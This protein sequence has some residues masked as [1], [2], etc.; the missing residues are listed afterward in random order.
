MASFMLVDSYLLLLL[1]AVWLCLLDA[2]GDPRILLLNNTRRSKS[3]FAVRC[4]H[5]LL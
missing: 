5:G 2:S 3:A 4:R 1:N